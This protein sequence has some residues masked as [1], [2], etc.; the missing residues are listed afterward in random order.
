VSSIRSN[1]VSGPHEVSAH[2]HPKRPPVGPVEL[3]ERFV[4]ILAT[5]AERAGSNNVN[6]LD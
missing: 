3:D 6:G 4:G 5:P 2:A 1:N